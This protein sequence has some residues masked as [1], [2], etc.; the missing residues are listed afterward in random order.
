MRPIAT[1]VA[2]MWYVGHSGELCKKRLNSELIEIPFRGLTPVSGTNSRE[3][4]EPLLDGAL[5]FR[6]VYCV[7]WNAKP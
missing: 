7:R 5:R 2:R 4:K 6:P 3:P 1:D